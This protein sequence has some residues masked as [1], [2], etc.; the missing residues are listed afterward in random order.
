MTSEGQGI[1]WVV[2]VSVAVVVVVVVF[3][4]AVDVTRSSVCVALLGTLRMV[5]AI[6]GSR[7]LLFSRVFGAFDGGPSAPGRVFLVWCRGLRRVRGRVPVV[8]AVV[9]RRLLWSS[10]LSL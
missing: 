7:R 10:S 1:G 8:L 5:I 3:V 2:V 4:V 6:S 9:V